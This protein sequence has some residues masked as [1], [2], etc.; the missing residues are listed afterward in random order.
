VA[1]RTAWEAVMKGVVFNL[2]EEVVVREFGPDTWDDLLEGA[3]VSGS[4]TSVGSYP[5]EEIEALVAT[6]AST[7]DLSR[8]EVLR[9]FGRQAMGVL[10]ERYQPFFAPHTT[11]RT[12]ILSVNSI[13][14]PE[15]RKLYAGAGCPHFHFREEGGLLL[16]RYDSP[17]RL[18]RLAEGFVEGAAAHYVETVEF[19]H[20]SC[21]E[22]GDEACEFR[23]AWV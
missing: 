22:H 1:A 17:R 5:D 11:A 15:V 20:L 9:W 19:Q 3:D 23:L 4:Y 2:L 10:A 6:A 13:I 8:G 14:H 18:C 21:M 16:M 12:F 7:L